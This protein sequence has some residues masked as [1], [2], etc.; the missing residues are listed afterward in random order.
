MYALSS[1]HCASIVRCEKVGTG[2]SGVGWDTIGVSLAQSASGTMT[3]K[4]NHER[5]RIVAEG[6][7]RDKDGTVYDIDLPP[8]LPPTPADCP[9]CECESIWTGRWGED[10][11][12]L[13]WEYKCGFCNQLWVGWVTDNGELYKGVRHEDK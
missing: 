8:I 11:E 1:E 9:A 5:S 10:D 2:Q 12:N 3:E 7:Y 4:K 6:Q 13:A